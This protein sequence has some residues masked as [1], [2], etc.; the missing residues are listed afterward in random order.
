MGC[1]EPGVYKLET[2][3]RVIRPK[4][5]SLKVNPEKRERGKV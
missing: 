2:E 5:I 1:V 4:Q 3:P